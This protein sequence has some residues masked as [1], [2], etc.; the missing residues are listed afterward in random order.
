MRNPFNHPDGKLPFETAPQVEV[1]D[2]LQFHL[3]QRIRDYIAQGMD[4]ATARATALERFG[5]VSGVQRECTELLVDDRRAERRRDWI[6]DLKQDLRFG[7]RSATHAKLF[8]LLAVVTLAFGIGANAAVF[9]VVKSVLLDALPYR[10]SNRLVRVS[11]HFRDGSSGLGGVSTGAAKDL[12]DRQR[13]FSTFAIFQGSTAQRVFKGDGGAR[14]VTLGWVQPGF[15][16]TLGVTPAIGRNFRDDDAL[17]DTA[18]SAMLTHSAWQQMFGGDPAIVGKAFQ[19]NGITRTVAG[20]LPASF[21]SPMGD[22]DVF[23]AM[24]LRSLMRDPVT[25][26]GSHNMGFVARLK[27]GVTIETARQDIAG[28]SNDLSREYPKD[29]GPF[30]LRA[31]LL[32]DSMVGDTR[33]PLLVLMASAGLVL[34]ITCANLAGALLSRTISR[35]K[36]FAVR[37]ALGA[38]RE[39][40]VRQLLTESTLLSLVGGV[41][42][43]LLALVGLTMMRRLA[44]NALPAYAH[45]ALDPGTLVYTTLLA[46]CTGLAFG[47]VPALSVGRTNMQGILR[48]ETR[49]SS[50]S[51]RSRQLRGALVA[52]QIALCLS[53]LTGAGLLTRSLYAM[54]TTPVGFNPE[55][56]L[57]VDVQ[58][59]AM[60]MTG[61]EQMSRYYSQLEERLRAIPGVTAIASVSELPNPRMD[62]NGLSIEGEPAPP[63]N[64]QPF[65]TYAS[66]SDDYFRLLGIPLRSGRSFGAEDRPDAPVS[67][68]ISAAMERKF[69]PNGGALGARI[70]LGPN[71]ESP[72]KVIVGVVGDVRN[73]PV[74]PEAQSMTYVSR[75]QEPTGNLSYLVRTQGN[76]LAL[77]KQIQAAATAFDPDLATHNI[78]TMSALLSE[79]LAGRRLPVVLMTGFGALALLL[80]S[81]GVYAMFAAMAAARERE[82][83]VRV[84]L[85]STRQGIAAL[86]LRQG[87]QWMAIGLAAGV[88]GVV[89]VGTMIRNLLY[90]VR[91]FDP[92]TLVVT[93]MM[94]V[95]C[96]SLALLAPLRRATQVDP[97]SVM[98]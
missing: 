63:N 32:R 20:V 74:S 61:V 40:L 9:G 33:T 15:F 79:G 25:V 87:A 50:E 66:V 81:V 75:R 65:V 18:W 88:V 71:A 12:A 41:A 58:P 59:P 29:D 7:V 48:D 42:G 98:R 77:T 54:M 93:A 39:R 13:S 49:G 68:V 92:V 38:G 70:R 96:A 24:S 5:D 4:P 78:T 64:Q 1:G 56:V 28:I 11:G 8:T 10:E 52:G 30:E 91:P 43:V 55:G 60:A 26:R 31:N 44:L 6:G 85:G 82:F 67:V 73:D 3:E 51:R 86:V 2:E 69:W 22:V 17:S 46:L 94:I 35:R 45:L 89:L 95:A 62:D 14:M 36:E 47:V 16:T 19:V 21:V 97:I 37:L 90:G 57:T 27:P 53:L 23:L 83:G 84:A 34:L 72:W 76:P 80:A